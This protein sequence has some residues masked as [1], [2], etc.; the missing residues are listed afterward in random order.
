MKIG[1]LIPFRGTVTDK[2]RLR[3]EITKDI[4]DKL[5]K[6]MIQH[7]I[8][9]CMELEFEKN[10]YV[11]TKNDTVVLE[12][13]YIILQDQGENLNDAIKKAKGKLEEDMLIVIMADLPFLKNEVVERIINMYRK[14]NQ[15]IIAPSNDNGTSILCFDTNANFPFVF[16]QKSSMHFQELFKNNNLQY[17]LLD[18]EI[19]FKDID[20]LKD[21]IEIGRLESL[22]EWLKEITKE[23]K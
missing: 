14:K 23:V 21:L 17:T 19:S 9:E 16:G 6:Q 5:L 15:I 18:Y 4:V 3:K 12:G 10:I 7:V 8:K 2:S 22:P 13:D 1:I 20:T 11:L